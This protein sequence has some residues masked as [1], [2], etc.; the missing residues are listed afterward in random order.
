MGARNLTQFL[1]RAV[2]AQ[3]LSHLS[4]SI[5]GSLKSAIATLHYPMRSVPLLVGL[6]GALGEAQK[7][8]TVSK[9]VLLITMNKAKTQRQKLAKEKPTNQLTS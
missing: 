8:Y 4:T 7:G 2:C 9:A 1:S 6:S 5:S 3:R